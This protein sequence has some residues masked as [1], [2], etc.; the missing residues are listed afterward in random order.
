VLIALVPIVAENPVL[1]VAAGSLAGLVGNFVLSRR[2]VFGQ[3]GSG[4]P[5]R[6]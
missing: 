6:S 4:R 5:S 3:G 2:F 1:G